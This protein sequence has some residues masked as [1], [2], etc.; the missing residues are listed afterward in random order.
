MKIKIYSLIVGLLLPFLCFSQTTNPSL[1]PVK[2]QQKWGLIDSSGTIRIEP[3]YDNLK[4]LHTDFNQSYYL[5]SRDKK[6]G[7]LNPNGQEIISTNYRRIRP[8]SDDYFAVIK[9]SLEIVIDKNEQQILKASFDYV[10]ML[11][12][13]FFAFKKGNLW[14]VYQRNK[15]ILFEPQFDEINPINEGKGY[16]GV[17]KMK[18]AVAHWGL[19]DKAGNLVI[20]LDY[21]DI[22][23]ID[24]NKV[25][26]KKENLWGMVDAD[27]K[28]IF[29]PKYQSYSKLSRYY[30]TYITPK[31]TQE[32]YLNLKNTFFT[33]DTKFRSYRL[34]WQDSTIIAAHTTFKMGILDSVGNVIIPPLFEN[35]ERYDGD[36]FKVRKG[37]WGLYNVQD[38]IVVNTNFDAIGKFNDDGFAMI[39]INNKFGYLNRK[40]EVVIP[41]MYTRLILYNRLLKAYDR[42]NLT[43]F[44]QTV[45][46]KFE[47]NDAYVNVKSLRVGGNGNRNNGFTTVQSASWQNPKE[48]GNYHWKKNENGLY[49]LQ[50][51]SNSN[52]WIVE[53]K[54]KHIKVLHRHN[55]TLV[56]NE[57]VD[58]AKSYP[59]FGRTRHVIYHPVQLFSNQNLQIISNEKII[60][61]RSSDY[62]NGSSSATFLGGNGQFG[63][64][65]KNGQIVQQP[66]KLFIKYF[67]KG[68]FAFPKGEQVV[69][70]NRSSK[71]DFARSFSLHRDFNIDFYERSNVLDNHYKVEKGFWGYCDENGKVI[72]KPQFTIIGQ[73]QTSNKV[74]NRTREGWGMMDNSGKTIVPFV[75]DKIDKYGTN[76]Y[77]LRAKNKLIITL[78]AT[79][80]ALD[81]QYIGQGQFFEGLARVAKR[82]T[83]GKLIW[84][85]VNENYE[86]IIPCQYKSAKNYKNGQT[87][88][89]DTAWHLMDKSGK[90][91]AT[92]PKVV[93]EIGEFHH[94]LA[95]AKLGESTYGYINT[96]GKFVI[97]PKLSKAGNFTKFGVANAAL[98][99]QS[100]LIDDKGMPIT[101]FGVYGNIFNIQPNGFA[102]VQHPRRRLYGLLNQSGKLVVPILYD[103][104]TPFKNGIATIKKYSKYGFIDK[105]G[106]VIVEPK[107][108]KVGQPSEGLIPVFMVEEKAWKYIDYQ[109]NIK[110]KGKFIEAAD[111]FQDYA[112]VKIDNTVDGKKERVSALI[113]KT[114]KFQFVSTIDKNLKYHTK[115]FRVIE[116]LDIEGTGSNAKSVSAMYY[117]DENNYNIFGREYKSVEPFENELGFV[118]TDN[119]WGAVNE[120][121]FSII[122]E[123]YVRLIRTK[124]GNVRG[125][126]KYLYG[127]CDLDGNMIQPVEFDN[128]YKGTDLYHVERDGKIGY[129]NLNG[130]WIWE[131]QE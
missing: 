68:L 43:F 47:L 5:I 10:T 6:I 118:V 18:G 100:I 46:D 22:D 56:Y 104:I 11:N 101:E 89:L 52:T 59:I 70:D 19:W 55:I 106:K 39:R 7:L 73:F 31:N 78:S 3:Q 123:K 114:G 29:E 44:N 108:D 87:A 60:G 12:S 121:G 127:L 131:I 105:N 71:F 117:A 81:D 82:D 65:H 26:V 48:F 115:G 77:L 30:S 2:V 91:I 9:D 15:G 62:D 33:S 36:I 129:L 112:V 53:P 69:S 45:E 27:G 84:G 67:E 35:I 54:Y 130:D 24:D 72:V 40:F 113:D 98:N 63:L 102:K 95:W 1:L 119:G 110:I 17:M 97:K 124:D 120:Q 38:S 86:E 107:Y 37:G 122:P 14:G 42:N 116:S 16:F 92:L 34:I 83:S 94:D 64:I 85:F 57:M 125:K 61:I 103:Q 88:V 21:Q 90:I 23:V 76:K 8:L 4:M 50:E 126:A 93:K 109:G 74:I 32:L 80:K 96:S 25:L 41:A 51:I 58:T 20:P 75:Y 79:G 111:F 66:N 128:I 28:Q 13:H 49:G 99:G